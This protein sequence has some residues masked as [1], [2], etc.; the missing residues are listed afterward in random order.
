M[1]VG[2]GYYRPI[3]ET[4]KHAMV[5]SFVKAA[6]GMYRGVE[7]RMADYAANGDQVHQRMSKLFLEAQK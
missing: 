5:R 2:P 4:R 6:K 3:D 7:K 1:D